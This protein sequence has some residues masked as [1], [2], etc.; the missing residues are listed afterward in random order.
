MSADNAERQEEG[1]Q[2]GSGINSE[3]VISS[4]AVIKGKRQKVSSDNADG[5]EEGEQNGSEMNS[6]RV[7]SSEA[8]KKGKRQKVSSDEGAP[9]NAEDSVVYTTS[10]QATK[11]NKKPPSSRRGR[12]E[13]TSSATSKTQKH[14]KTPRGG[15]GPVIK[16]AA[17]ALTAKRA[18]T[19]ESVSNPIKR[20][21]N[22]KAED[23]SDVDVEMDEDVYLSEASSDHPEED[24]LGPQN[25]VSLS[26]KSI[27]YASAD[28]DLVS[29][30][31]HAIQMLGGFRLW[32]RKDSSNSAPPDI[33]VLSNKEKPSR[34]TCRVLETIA[35]GG[36]LITSDWVD[37]SI[38]AGKWLDLR[39]FESSDFSGARKSRI[40]HSKKE[41]GI[42]AG[43]RIALEGSFKLDLPSI[44]RLIKLAD[45]KVV[46][47]RPDYVL[48]G[49]DPVDS[50]K[51]D[52]GGVRV[53]DT[54]LF[55]SIEH[56]GLLDLKNYKR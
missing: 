50:S 46:T 52:D 55:D 44:C 37:E 56:W 24:H 12:K 21:K 53:R 2:S 6:E 26:S 48:V 29:S 40:S 54:W 47:S 35:S 9:S 20:G 27:A 3:L 51:S 8:M 4:A 49:S 45:G 7:I 13:S 16:K 39:D 33:M 18:S 11:V 41:K 15:R 22:K 10:P 17:N 5:K 28:D 38:S 14:Q 23:V 32:L 42:L 19:A 25:L 31:H 30:I 36:F 43:V 34:R 1:G